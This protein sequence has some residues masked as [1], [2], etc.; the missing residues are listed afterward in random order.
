MSPP[1]APPPPLRCPLPG[2]LGAAQTTIPGR[3]LRCWPT[4][5]VP[6]R[7]PHLAHPTSATRWGRACPHH[8]RRPC[9]SC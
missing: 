8:R 5:R 7:Q 4:V 3:P 6:E 2:W 9:P 1:P